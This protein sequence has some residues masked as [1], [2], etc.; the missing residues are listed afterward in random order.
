MNW[1]RTL[2]DR[3][4]EWQVNRWRAR[5]RKMVLPKP[6]ADSRANSARARQDLQ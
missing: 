1:L 6:A 5:F 2:L 3:F 4:H